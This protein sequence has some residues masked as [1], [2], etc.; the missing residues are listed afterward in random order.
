MLLAFA[1]GKKGNYLHVVSSGPV[2]FSRGW[3]KA[4]TGCEHLT[5][6]HSEE[7]A[8]VKILSL[9]ELLY[10]NRPRVLSSSVLLLAFAAVEMTD[11]SAL[12]RSL[13]VMRWFVVS[14]DSTFLPMAFKDVNT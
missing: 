12:M 6:D 7:K 3:A 5:A 9:A 11:R 1:C 14:R 10:N 4:V 8:P 2:D 13:L